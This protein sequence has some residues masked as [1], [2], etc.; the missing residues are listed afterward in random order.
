MSFVYIMTSDSFLLFTY[1]NIVWQVVLFFPKSHFFLAMDYCQYSILPR[2]IDAG[3]SNMTGFD[4]WNVSKCDNVWVQSLG[5]SRH[6]CFLS[7]LK[8]CHCPSLRQYSQ[9]KPKFNLYPTEALLSQP[10]H[11]PVNKKQKTKKNR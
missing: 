5:F 10:T 3:P 7:P 4:Q 1:T 11:R 6:L 2:P 8:C 9:N